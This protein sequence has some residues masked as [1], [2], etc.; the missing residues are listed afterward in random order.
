MFVG[1]LQAP[2]KSRN[3]VLHTQKQTEPKEETQREKWYSETTCPQ[4]V[5]LEP[6]KLLFLGFGPLGS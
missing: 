6:V 3:F 5:N 4:S 1:G 2:S